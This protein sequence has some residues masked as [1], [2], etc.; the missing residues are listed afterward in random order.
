MS[1]QVEDEGTRVSSGDYYEESYQHISPSL[2]ATRLGKLVAAGMVVTVGAFTLQALLPAGTPPNSIEPWIGPL[3]FSF[4]WLFFWA[5]VFEG[6]LVI[7]YR[8]LVSG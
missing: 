6:L 1:S 7:A 5:I 8:D 3:P 2:P 4:A